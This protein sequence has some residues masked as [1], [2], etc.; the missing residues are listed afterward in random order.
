MIGED[1]AFILYADNKIKLAKLTFFSFLDWFNYDSHMRFNQRIGDILSSLWLNLGTLLGIGKKLFS[2]LNT[3]VTLLFF[4]L[5]FFWSNCRLPNIK[6]I[7]D[8]A[9]FSAIPI[10]FLLC[11]FS[12]GE[13]FI[14][15]TGA[16]NY[17]W[18]GSILLGVAIPYRKYLHDENYKTK[19]KLI[20]GY[21][22]VSYIAAFTNENTVPIIILL[23]GFL[24]LRDFVKKGIKKIPVWLFLSVFFM[25]IGYSI[26]LFSPNTRRR[27]LVYRD[28]F[29]LP[30]KMSFGEIRN[31]IERVFQYFTD[32]NYRFIII[33]FS[34]LFSLFCIYFFKNMN[35]SLINTKNI[36]EYKPHLF[37]ISIITIGILFIISFLNNNHFR[38]SF[39]YFILLLYFAII[40][41]LLLMKWINIKKLY[42][43]IFILLV[44]SISIAALFFAPYTEIRTFFFVQILIISIIVRINYIALTTFPVGVN[45][46]LKYIPN[47]CF[48]LLSIIFLDRLLNWTLDYSKFD[49]L[50]TES[51]KRQVAEGKTSVI[52]KI[53]PIEKNKYLNTREIWLRDLRYRSKN[54]ERFQGVEKIIWNNFSYEEEKKESKYIAHI[55][56]PKYVSEVLTNDIFSINIKNENLVLV[57]G[58]NDPQVF[59]SLQEPIEKPSGV[60][61]IEIDYT[62]SKTGILQIYYDFGN[63]LSEENS[64]RY[65]IENISEMTKIRLPIVGWLARQRLYS[66][67]I[68][69]PD[70]TIF[71]IK[72]I[73]FGEL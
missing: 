21:V 18:A 30:E 54:Y 67:R 11:C 48:C 23:G 31:N 61:C 59:L 10:L 55:S 47:I 7:K 4:I 57:C 49:Y 27:T 68:D 51:I 66:I 1:Y 32:S 46:Y 43:N 58:I 70:G 3:I 41:Y 2:F 60:P 63:G 40:T 71:E 34:V 14:W 50:R 12:I 56:M 37:I 44:S 28:M 62:N 13:I 35:I 42:E 29:N 6:S 53:Y 5:I 45:K 20:L 17:L 8:L 64:F 36:K 19:N 72:S 22:I 73:V 38:I 9:I 16:T 15:C 39:I 52:A 26:L 25:G 69:P 33:L 65:D 24:I